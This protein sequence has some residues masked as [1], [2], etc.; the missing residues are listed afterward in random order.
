MN[1]TMSRLYTSSGSLRDYGA[2]GLSI[3]S[4]HRHSAIYSLIATLRGG[5]SHSVIIPIEARIGSRSLAQTIP[6]GIPEA[7]RKRG[8][9]DQVEGPGRVTHRASDHRFA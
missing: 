4:L 3:S 8:V 5:F 1:L 7:R 9:M 2:T 6:S